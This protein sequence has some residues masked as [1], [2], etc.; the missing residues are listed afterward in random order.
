[1]HI[2][3]YHRIGL[4]STQGYSEHTLHEV[5]SVLLTFGTTG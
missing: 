4:L 2:Y 1:M 3:K 5:H